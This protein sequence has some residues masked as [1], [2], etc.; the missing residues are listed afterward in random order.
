MSTIATLT[1]EL[2]YRLDELSAHEWDDAAQLAP[3]INRAEI[4]VG[5]L[6]GNLPGCG[7]FLYRDTFSL[8]AS[9]TTKALSTL[10]KYFAEM[11]TVSI[12]YD[13]T[14]WV[15]MRQMDEE[16]ENQLRNDATVASGIAIPRWRL[17]DTDIQFLPPLT[18]AR[19]V[20]LSYR[21]LPAV[22]SSGTIETP[23]TE[24][25]L[26][27]LRASHFALA[28]RRETNS[29][30]ETEYAVRIGE[31]IDRFSGRQFGARGERVRSR[32]ARSYYG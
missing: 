20:A 8:T 19:T 9:T 11:R 13:G 22:K 24:D 21:W 6:I 1:T 3:F 30:F 15:N 17:F 29:A 23:A 26:V 2:R 18:T 5:D 25:D 27:V 14:H 16:D 28:D 10:T 12:Q 7:L 32:V 31:T 4:W